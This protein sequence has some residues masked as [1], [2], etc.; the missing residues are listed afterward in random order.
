M[1]GPV[2]EALMWKAGIEGQT[3]MWKAVTVEQALMWKAG[4]A[5]HSVRISP[6][7]PSILHR[8]DPPCYVSP[9]NAS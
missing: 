5:G 8:V 2:R 9:R 6:T 4:T 7:I 3:G 1:A